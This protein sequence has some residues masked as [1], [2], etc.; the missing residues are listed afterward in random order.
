[1]SACQAFSASLL[2]SL[3]ATEAEYHQGSRE[4]PEKREIK[5]HAES[6]FLCAVV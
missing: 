5:L 4:N 3:L 1:M 6:E 2:W